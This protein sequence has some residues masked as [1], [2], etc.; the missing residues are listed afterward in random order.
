LDSHFIDLRAGWPA[1]QDWS[2]KNSKTIKRQGQK[3]RSLIRDVGPLKFEF[4]C[5]NAEVLEQLIE[6]KRSK[7]TRSKTFDILS[8]DWAANLLREISTIETPNFQGLLSV[9]FAGDELVA[10][11]FGMLTDDVLH[12]WFPVFDPAFSRYS[13]GTELIL[14]VAEEAA[15]RGVN[16]VD[17]GYGDDLYKFKFCNGRESVCCGKVTTKELSF[18]I[19]KRRYQLRQKLKAIPMKKAAKSLLRK[20]FPGFGQWNFK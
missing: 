1:Y 16:K 13:P 6:L 10:V 15:K 2:K 14:S 20:V 18:Q 5:A 19:A 4:D 17:F 7:Y 3:T 12:Y 11:H 9:L 8:V